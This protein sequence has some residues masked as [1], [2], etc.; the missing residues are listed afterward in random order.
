[1]RI[2]ILAVAL[3]V[4]AVACNKKNN[5]AP[6]TETKKE[7]PKPS[8][9]VAEPKPVAP[10]TPEPPAPEPP[11]SAPAGTTL[12]DQLEASFVRFESEGVIAVFKLTNK[13]ACTIESY[14]YRGY[15]YDKA[16]KKLGGATGGGGL[17]LAPGKSVEREL[18]V[19]GKKDATAEVVITGVKCTDG[20][21]WED[22][23]RAPF[24]R[25][26]GGKK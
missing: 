6:P 13:S 8:P 20:K 26:M 5:D 12:G 1:M 21:T 25:P 17:G 19:N 18:R 4:S 16:G 3:T 7:E 15:A 23:D 22:N 2:I 11:K 10:P 24:D 9:K 14:D